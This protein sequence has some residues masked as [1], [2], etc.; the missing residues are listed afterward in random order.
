LNRA[1]KQLIWIAAAVGVA[2]ILFAQ[3]AA[4]PTFRFAILGDR[5]G[6]TVPGMYEAVWHEISAANPAF[7]VGVGDSIQGLDDATAESEWLAFDRA[8]E[9]FRKLPYFPAPGNHDVWSDA[10]AKLFEKHG[11]HP[12]HYSFDYGPAHFTILDNSRTDD[13]QPGEMTFLEQDLQ[14]HASQP[15]K[16]IVSHRPSW[17]LNVILRSPD[18]PLQ[19]LAG[20]YGVQGVIAGHVHEMM[21]GSLGGVE[22]ISVPS[23]GGHLR[24]SGKYEDGWFFGY[25]MATISGTDVTFEVRELPPPNGEGR[26]TPLSAWGAAGLVRKNN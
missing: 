17:L 14:A 2:A 7:V 11:D 16:F 15:V 3:S 5:T 24:L 12:L 8:R 25:I 23:A 13:L 19:R 4:T 9:P 21:H 10:S 20:K 22:Y 1:I 18:F 26:V 6:E